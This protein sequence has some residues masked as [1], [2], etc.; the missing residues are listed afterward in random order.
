MNKIAVGMVSLGCPK[1]EIDGEHILHDLAEDP[2]FDL[3]EEQ[4]ADV[5]IIHTCAFIQAAREEA[6]GAILDACGRKEEG[7][8]KAVVVTGC[9][10]QRYQQELADEI[11]EVDVILGIG[12][13]QQIADAI[14]SA[15]GGETVLSIGQKEQLRL[16]HP[17]LLTTPPHYAYL[18]I[19]EGCDN[20]CSYCA[21]PYIRGRFRSRPMDEI[22]KEAELLFRQGVKELIVIAQ[23]TTRYGEDWG[24]ASRLPE[25]LRALS[26]IGFVWIRTLY[27]YPERITDELLNVI[28]EEPAVLPYF[29]I[30]IQHCNDEILRRMNRKITGLEIRSLLDRIRSRIPEAVLRTSLIAGFPG[31]TEEQFDELLRFVEEVKFDRM[32]CFAYSQE[33]GT[34]AGRMEGQLPDWIKEERAERI[35]WAQQQILEEKARQKTG[36]TLPVLCEEETPGGFIGRTAADAPEIDCSIL[37]SADVSVPI[38]SLVLAKIVGEENGDLIGQL[39]GEEIQ[40]DEFT[41]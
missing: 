39:S 27:C 22:L 4:E 41:K 26:N 13:H 36:L 3:A 25:L 18:K 11:P 28:S 19:A 23:N 6:I 20:Y 34:P 32:G 40:N 24:G 33:E 29:D 38:G 15:L 7:T 12:A 37:V 31:E 2:R 14:V 35:Q 1:N 30:P 10:A 17:R 16:S 21:I 8:L 5:L 9:L